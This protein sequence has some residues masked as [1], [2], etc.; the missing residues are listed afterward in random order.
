MRVENAHPVRGVLAVRRIP[1]RRAAEAVGCS[2]EHLSLVLNGYRRPSAH[3]VDRLAAF[4]GVPSD[5]LFD[6]H[7]CRC[8]CGRGLAS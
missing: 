6:V 3:L 5:G 2:P 8:A 1:V 4:L 7:V